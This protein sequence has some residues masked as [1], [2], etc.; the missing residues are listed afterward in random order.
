VLK[1]VG[2]Q[3]YLLELPSLYEKICPIFHVSKLKPYT[4]D[5]SHPAALI[6]A[7][8]LVDNGEKEFEVDFIINHRGRGRGLQYLVKW[9]GYD[10]S[11]ATWVKAEHLTNCG[12]ALEA[13]LANRVSGPTPAN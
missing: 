13:Y 2:S 12:E 10:I 4:D 8:I 5:G 3:S 11:E 9:A 7:P 1:R 6:P